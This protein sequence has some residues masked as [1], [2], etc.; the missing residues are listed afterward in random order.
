[1][2]LESRLRAAGVVAVTNP[3]APALAEALARTLLEAGIGVIEL[4]FRATGA[5]AAIDRIR[6][7]VPEMLVG[8][9]T[10]LTKVQ[11]REALDAGAEFVVAPGSNPDVIETV[12]G[13]GATM[14]PGVATPSEIEAGFARGVRLLKLF[15]A[16]IV[17]GVAMIKAMRGPYPDVAFLP[18]GGIGPANLSAYLAQ[19]NVVA[20]GGSWLTAR[21]ETEADLLRVGVVARAAAAQVR[22]ARRAAINQIESAERGEDAR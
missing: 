2:R 5:P 10:V 1:M 16:E 9:G 3:P 17:G 4:T 11:A 21:V 8:A 19:P 20:C 13:R 18:T 15:P 22:E 7:T 14:I 6:T 12:L